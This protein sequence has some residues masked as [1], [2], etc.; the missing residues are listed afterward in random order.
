M[1]VVTSC[2]A[3]LLFVACGGA[4]VDSKINPKA[5]EN[6]EEVQK[7]YDAILKCMGGQASKADEVYF[8]IDNP[9]DKGKSGD[10][11]LYIMI[12][13]QDP[14][15]PKQLVRQLFHGELGYWQPLQE[16]TVQVNGT[17]EEKANFKLEDELFDFSGQIKAES[18]FKIIQDAYAKGNTESEKFSYRYVQGVKISM[19]GYDITVKSKLASNDQIINE[20]YTVDFAGNF[21]D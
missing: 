5:F 11:Y 8:Y 13:M 21:I 12:D 4:G 16:V 15:N 6:K 14:S 3:S 2:F 17:D 10:A 1:Y 9:A 18:L 20:Y 19:S 7:V